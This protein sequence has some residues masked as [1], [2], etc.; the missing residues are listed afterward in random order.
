MVQSTPGIPLL[1][2]LT[3]IQL[4]DETLS[5]TMTYACNCIGSPFRISAGPDSWNRAKRWRSANHFSHKDKRICT[6][7]SYDNRF[8]TIELH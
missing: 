3:E 5:F 6:Y 2:R 8:P 7:K 1:S 4:E